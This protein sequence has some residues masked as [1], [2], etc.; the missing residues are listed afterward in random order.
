MTD[1]LEQ[2][3]VEDFGAQN[4]PDEEKKHVVAPLHPEK[5][6][7]FKFARQI[8]AGILGLYTLILIGYIWM[9]YKGL[10][11]SLLSDLLKSTFPPLVF[12]VIGAFFREKAEKT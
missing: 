11:A 5:A 12:L 2:A 9:V 1:N 7:L 10:D 4:E 8:L 6:E 3:T